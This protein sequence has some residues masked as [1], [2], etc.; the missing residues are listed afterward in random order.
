MINKLSNRAWTTVALAP[1]STGQA[2]AIQWNTWENAGAPPNDIEN[3]VGQR[4]MGRVYRRYRIINAMT[5]VT[6]VP[7]KIVSNQPTLQ[8]FRGFVYLYCYQSNNQLDEVLNVGA[9]TWSPASTSDPVD[10]R[11]VMQ[12]P[13]VK[14]KR[15][16]WAEVPQIKSLTM[17]CTLPQSNKIRNDPAYASDIGDYSG[18]SNVAATPVFSPPARILWFHFGLFIPGLT[19]SFLATDDI[20]SFKLEFKD[21]TLCTWTSPKVDAAQE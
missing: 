7:N 12:I 18:T 2:M 4:T 1:N 11:K 14:I 16:R 19:P 9:P 5:K 21:I 6:F 17:L 10:I 3:W 20:P 15:L 13:G 8:R